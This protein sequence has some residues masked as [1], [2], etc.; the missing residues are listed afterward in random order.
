MTISQINWPERKLEI[1]NS[2]LKSIEEVLKARILCHALSKVCKM[3]NVNHQKVSL[4]R[5]ITSQLGRQEGHQKNTFY[6]VCP[7]DQR[8]QKLIKAKEQT[9]EDNR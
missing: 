2:G 7:D 4:K 6:E 9:D 3:S 8:G 5:K 1:K